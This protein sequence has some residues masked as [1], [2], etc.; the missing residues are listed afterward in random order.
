MGAEKH[1]RFAPPPF[2]QRA[3]ADRVRVSI[4]SPGRS[5]PFTD[6]A[7]KARYGHFLSL[8]EALRQARRGSGGER[9]PGGSRSPRSR[10]VWRITLSTL[11]NSAAA[12]GCGPGTGETGPIQTKVA[13]QRWRAWMNSEPHSR[14]R[15]YTER[16]VFLYP[17]I[18][19]FRSGRR[20][21]RREVPAIGDSG[22]HLSLTNGSWLLCIAELGL[23][24]APHP[25]PP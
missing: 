5:L 6:C 1:R 11:G 3:K 25:N 23:T 19:I 10:P 20:V 2:R 21:N 8:K 15:R 12:D 9:V 16:Y 4:R 24:K 18:Y 7:R 22:F 14:V 13:L 17:L